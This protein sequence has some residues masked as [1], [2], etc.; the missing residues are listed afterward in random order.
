MT[1]STSRS[2]TT[3]INSGGDVYD[4]EYKP[5]DDDNE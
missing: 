5:V 1:R 2:T 3:T 4:A